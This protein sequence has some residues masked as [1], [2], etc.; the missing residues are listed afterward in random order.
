LRPC[1]PRH[2]S[3]YPDFGVPGMSTNVV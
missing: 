2:N 1:R 3:A